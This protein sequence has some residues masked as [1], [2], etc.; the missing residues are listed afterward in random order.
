MLEEGKKKWVLS[1]EVPSLTQPQNFG[2]CKDQEG[3]KKSSGT[4]S[5]E[6]ARAVGCGG[7]RRAPR[8][9]SEAGAGGFR[10]AKGEAPTGRRSRPAPP[11]R[12]PGS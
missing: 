7:P 5:G 2:L 4:R 9:A 6:R 11:P 8:A 1:A 10:A 12:R 3:Q